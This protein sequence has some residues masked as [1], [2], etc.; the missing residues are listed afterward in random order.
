MAKFSPGNGKSIINIP[1]TLKKYITA[2]K[3]VAKK[4]G[5]NFFVNPATELLLS[6]RCVALLYCW[7]MYEQG[8]VQFKKF[9]KLLEN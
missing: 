2:L 7:N 8:F 9:T 1:A 4:S 5:N 6:I 3:I